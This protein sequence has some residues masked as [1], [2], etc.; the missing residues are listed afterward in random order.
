MVL[1]PLLAAMNGSQKQ[2]PSEQAA[3]DKKTETKSEDDLNAEDSPDDND[4]HVSQESLQKVHSR[5]GES[6][7]AS[8]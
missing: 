6:P 7:T 5:D 3:A 8:A 2:V 4:E 1:S